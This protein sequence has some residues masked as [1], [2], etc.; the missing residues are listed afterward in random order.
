MRSRL[1]RDNLEIGAGFRNRRERPKDFAAVIVSNV[2]GS[3]N[4]VGEA[5]AHMFTYST[6]AGAARQEVEGGACP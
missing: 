6:E 1:S 2:Q 3:R 4:V 5:A